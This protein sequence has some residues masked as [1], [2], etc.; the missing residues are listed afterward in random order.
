MKKYELSVGL[1]KF[2]YLVFMMGSAAGG[3]MRQMGKLESW[4]DVTWVVVF[5]GV[6]AAADALRN[7]LKV[8]NPEFGRKLSKIPVIGFGIFVAASM[9]GCAYQTT[10]FVEISREADGTELT[11]K[12][13]GTTVTPPLA[14]RETANLTWGYELDG[15]HSRIRTGQSETGTDTTAQSVFVEMLGRV[16]GQALA[17]YA[18]SEARYGNGSPGVFGDLLELMVPVLRGAG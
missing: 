9:V 8:E 5:V 18:Q 6:A 12:W 14:K 4:E 17:S 7:Y 3:A 2:A 15:G 11:T 1:R 13:G 10:R 16:I